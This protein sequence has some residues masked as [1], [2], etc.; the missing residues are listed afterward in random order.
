MTLGQ[1]M[2]ELKSYG[3]EQS[4]KIYTNHGATGDMFG[5][6]VGDMKKIVKKVKKNHEL[7]LQLFAT[8]NADAQY[9]AGLI[10]DEK[11]IRKEELQQ[12]AEQ[13]NWYMVSEYAVANVCAETSYGWELALQW[14]ES[15]NKR[16][17]SAGWSALSGI[18]STI[19]NDKLDVDTIKSL[20]FRVKNEIHEAHNRVR[21]T[22]NN[23]VIGVGCYIEELHEES[24][25]VANEIG[26]VD[27]YMG[28]TSCKVPFAPQYIQKVVDKGYLGR[29]RKV[30]RC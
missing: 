2:Q 4:R 26:K 28:K 17:A 29:K 27:V 11:K 3:N 20:L 10:A 16:V 6:K 19:D 22:M 30:A 1:I 7:S 14:I 21:Y 8:G 9:L 15:D 25:I 18:I 5:V 12:W 23:F 24:V 13:S